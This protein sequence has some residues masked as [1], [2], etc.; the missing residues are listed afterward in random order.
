ME[1]YER[2]TVKALASRDP[3]E[4]YHT[5]DLEDAVGTAKAQAKS[6]GTAFS[7]VDNRRRRRV[8]IA[9]PSGE[10]I[11][12]PGGFSTP[13]L[14]EDAS[15]AISVD[16]D[17]LRTMIREAVQ[18]RLAEGKGK[19]T[20]KSEKHDQVGKKH[21]KGKDKELEDKKEID[22]AKKHL[23]T[24]KDSLK[25][26]NRLMRK[27]EEKVIH[28]PEGSTIGKVDSGEMELKD[29]AMGGGVPGTIGPMEYNGSAAME[30]ETYVNMTEGKNLT[31]QNVLKL[32]EAAAVGYVK[33]FGSAKDKASVIFNKATKKAVTESLLRNLKK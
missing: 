8:G 32:V 2:Y 5:D 9:Q 19:P 25:E 23:K 30:L 33:K 3:D 12:Q 13:K 26:A 29:E 21:L 18:K 28:T 6:M 20:D 15:G 1:E 17:S 10:L 14:S 24:A 22:L 16:V 11:H 27:L 4:G 31:S 7:I